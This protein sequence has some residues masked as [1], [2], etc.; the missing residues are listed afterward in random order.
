MLVLIRGAGDI[1]TGIAL[2][3]WRSHIQVIMT[4]LAQPTAIRRTVAFSQAILAG[5]GIEVEGVAGAPV[6]PHTS[7]GCDC[8]CDL[9][10]AQPG[11]LHHGCP[12]G[13]GSGTGV[14][15]RSGLPCGD[16]DHAGAHTWTGHLS[17]KRSTQYRCSGTGG[18]FCWREGPPRSGGGIFPSLAGNRRT[19]PAGR[20]GCHSGGSAHALHPG[21]YSEGDSSRGDASVCGDEGG[22]Y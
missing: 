16:R 19:S 18:R 11:H 4:D 13:G 10:Q 22:R 12:S 1:A 8:R 15:R 14:Y 20:H 5:A 7:A 21:R 3:L 6:H 2:R 9:G 17:W